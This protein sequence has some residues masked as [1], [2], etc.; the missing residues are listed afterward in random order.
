[1]E[2]KLEKPEK[3]TREIYLRKQKKTIKKYENVPTSL[4]L[5]SISTN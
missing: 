2:R 4:L 1:M 5:I 3:Y